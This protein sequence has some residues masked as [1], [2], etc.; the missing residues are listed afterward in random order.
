MQ[1]SLVF[2]HLQLTKETVCSDMDITGR[3]YDR[4]VSDVK[5]IKPWMMRLLIDKWKVNPLYIYDGKGLM[6]LDNI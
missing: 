1:L 3:M 2:D 4:M 6:T 5:Y